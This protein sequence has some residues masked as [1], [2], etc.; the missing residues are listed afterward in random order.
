MA[1]ANREEKPRLTVDILILASQR[2]L[3]V[4]VA[5]PLKT[6]TNA[7]GFNNRPIWEDEEW[8]KKYAKPLGQDEAGEEAATE[9]NAV[10][11]E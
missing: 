5:K 4:N 7:S 6:S 11:G 9:S 8:I 10:S 2:I 1:T 3:S